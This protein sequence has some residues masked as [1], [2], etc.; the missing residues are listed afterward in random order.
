LK[1]WNSLSDGLTL[2]LST[3]NL[4]LGCGGPTAAQSAF[5]MVLDSFLGIEHAPDTK[6]FLDGV[7]TQ[8]PVRHRN[9]LQ[10]IRSRYSLKEFLVKIGSDEQVKSAST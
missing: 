7:K 10:L 6:A 2:E 3:G 8:M 9:F 5:M 1:G 4:K